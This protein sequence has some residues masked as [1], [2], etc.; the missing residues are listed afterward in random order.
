MA[1]S[2]GTTVAARREERERVLRVLR[3]QER[4]LRARGLTRLAL[5]GSIARGDIG[6]DSDVDLLIEVDAAHRFGLFAFL[7]LKNDLAGLLGRPVDLGFPDAMRPRLRA[8]VLGEAVEGV[9]IAAPRDP[10]IVLEQML[11]AIND[12]AQILAG[13]SLQGLCRRSSDQ[14]CGGALHRDR[15]RGLA[16]PPAEPE[17]SPPRDSVAENR[18]HR[19]R[20][21][22]RR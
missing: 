21:A 1:V 5:F 16:A 2:V 13:R 20:A 11:E 9:L 7:D 19:Q 14:A 17:R 10:R 4:A 12:I 22:T 6:P 3:G 8:A 18:R 15:L